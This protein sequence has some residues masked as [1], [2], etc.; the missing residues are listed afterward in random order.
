MSANATTWLPLATLQRELRLPT[1]VVNPDLDALLTG[2]I[3]SS[4]DWI[5]RQYDIPL[6]DRT[7]TYEVCRNGPA[8]PLYL[9]TVPWFI[10]ATAVRAWT[11]ATTWAAGPPDRTVAPWGRVDMRANAG[12]QNTRVWLFPPPDGWPSVWNGQ[13]EVTVM[14]GARASDYPMVR[15]AAILVCRRLFEG[16]E[17]VRARSAVHELLAPLSGLGAR[18]ITGEK[19]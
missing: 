17:E 11:D 2:H 5:E 16:W 3:Q 9:G 8:L 15:Q 19:R 14:R 10:D 12:P 7:E 18:A 1:D 13:F 4:I 6:I